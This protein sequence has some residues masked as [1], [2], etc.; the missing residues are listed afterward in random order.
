M[1][2]QINSCF[3][4]HKLSYDCCF[5]SLPC[6]Y[7]FYTHLQHCNLLMETE[8]SGAN[9]STYSTLQYLLQLS[10]SENPESQQK[11]GKLL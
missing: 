9:S 4:I 11:A 1:K 5:V 7:V 3:N 2:P 8:Y 10:Y 6:T